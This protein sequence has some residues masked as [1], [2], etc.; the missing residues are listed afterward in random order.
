[1]F[2]KLRSLVL[3][4]LVAGFL[5]ACASTQQQGA[6]EVYD[7]LTFTYDTAARTLARTCVFH[8]VPKEQCDQW[9]KLV[10][11]TRELLL[12][13]GEILDKIITL[14]SNPNLDPYCQKLLTTCPPSDFQCL[15]QARQAC[16]RRYY[17]QFWQ[18]QR[19]VS[20]LLRR[21][22]QSLNGGGSQANAGSDRNR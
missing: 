9:G 19:L 16:L 12:E 22:Y 6:L 8:N 3:V 14:S 17:E 18:T 21:L 10:N 1:M 4:L 20:D 13:M 11:R 5:S 2:S 15:Q 7:Q